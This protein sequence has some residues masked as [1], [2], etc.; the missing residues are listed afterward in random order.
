MF[1]KIHELAMAQSEK[2]FYL[3]KSLKKIDIGSVFK[4][5]SF[6]QILKIF[7]NWIFMV[8]FY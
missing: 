2:I 7:Q 8:C 4:F 5:H 6:Y 3:A 1:L